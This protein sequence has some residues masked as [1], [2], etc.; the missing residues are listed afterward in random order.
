M[1][2]DG[3]DAGWTTVTVQ[4]PEFTTVQAQAC[5]STVAQ[6]Q[7]SLTNSDLTLIAGYPRITTVSFAATSGFEIQSPVEG[8]VLVSLRNA[9]PL[10]FSVD[11]DYRILTHYIEDGSQTVIR[12]T[13]FVEDKLQLTLASFTPTISASGIP[14]SNLMWD[15]AATGFRINVKN[16][17][18][19]PDK[20]ISKLSSLDDTSGWITALDTFSASEQMPPPGAMIDWSQD[21]TTSSGAIVRPNS[22]SIDGGH[23]AADL[24][25]N[26]TTIA[27]ITNT[28]PVTVK[29]H[30]NWATP[31]TIVSIQQLTGA[32][33]LE[34]YR[35]VEYTISTS[36]LRFASSAVNVIAPVGGTVSNFND[37]GIFTFDN[38]VH[39]N[40]ICADYYF[41][42]RTDFTRPASV[43]GRE[44]TLSTSTTTVLPVAHFTY[45]SL[46][47]FTPG[48]IIT[49]TITDFV[50]GDTFATNVRVL[51]DSARTFAGYITNDT[52]DPMAAWF[53]IRASASQPTIFRTGIS[54]SLL[55]NVSVTAGN[56]IDL[57]PQP[58]PIGYIP[59]PYKLYGI[60]LQP[61][62]TF[63]SIA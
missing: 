10:Y 61:G 20:W 57:A 2:I 4:E 8:Q 45:P 55:N 41:V 49:P 7:V 51:G 42:V 33:F 25:F 39:K 9:N 11:G 43:T 47:A 56:L 3:V 24:R 6:I 60:T 28:Y 38:P 59:E 52:P 5:F 16:P 48:I 54:P 40:S 50:S 36:G 46:I 23:V 31:A 62:I 21:F 32:T 13:E 30:I 58:E 19:F 26:Y 17:S 63:V 1:I 18:D 14:S 44:Y 35:D 29:L 27:G 34:S 53:A 22:T 15:Q 37:S 12:K